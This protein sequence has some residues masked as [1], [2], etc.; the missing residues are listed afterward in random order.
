M[1]THTNTLCTCKST[2][3]SRRYAAARKLSYFKYFKNKGLCKIIVSF[4]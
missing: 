4:L 1:Y 3:L 2:G